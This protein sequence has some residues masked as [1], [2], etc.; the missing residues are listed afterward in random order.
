MATPAERVC[1][2]CSQAFTEASSSNICQQCRSALFSLAGDDEEEDRP[3]EL[4]TNPS[5][6]V[7]NP[8]HRLQGVLS[9]RDFIRKLGAGGMG[10]VSLLRHRRLDRC[11]ALKVLLPALAGS[12]RFVERFLRESKV[13]AQLRHPNIVTVYDCSE[14]DDIL[15]ILM[16][17]VDGGSLREAIADNAFD[18]PKRIDIITQLAEGLA[19]A[20]REGVI[21]RDIKPANILLTQSGEVK[22]ADFGLSKQASTSASE[23]SMTRP[24]EAMGTFGYMAPEQQTGASTGDTRSDVYA[25]G[26]LCYELFTQRLPQGVFPPPSTEAGVSRKIDEVILKALEHDPQARYP[27]AGAFLKAWRSA[28]Q[29]ADSRETSRPRHRTHS[30]VRFFHENKKIGLFAAIAFL[31][32]MLPAFLILRDWLPSSTESDALPNTKQSNEAEVSANLT[33]EFIVP[34]IGIQLKW[35]PPGQTII[36]ALNAD[37][38]DSSPPLS[39]ELSYGFWMGIHEVTQFQFVHVMGSNPSGYGA[40]S[41]SSEA[42]SWRHR[43]VD[44]VSWREAVAFC[45]KLTQ[46]SRASGLIPPNF[47]FR[48][49]TEIEWEYVSRAGNQSISAGSFTPALIKP[50]AWTYQDY[51]EVEETQPV[52][53]K[54][55]NA[56][57]FYDMLGNVS[58]YCLNGWWYYP[59]FENQSIRDFVSE[60]QHEDRIYRGGSFAQGADRAVPYKRSSNALDERDLAQGFRIALSEEFP[61]ISDMLQSA[62][63][64]AINIDALGLSMNWIPA[65]E[66]IMGESTPSGPRGADVYPAT[67]TIISEGFWMGVTEVT[68]FQWDRVSAGDLTWL[69]RQTDT[70]HD[71][72]QDLPANTLSWNEATNFCHKLTIALKEA[73]KLQNDYVIRLPTEAEWE[74]ACRREHATLYTFGDDP[75]DLGIDFGERARFRDNGANTP[76]PVGGKTAGQSGLKGMYGNVREWCQDWKHSYTGQQQT[77]PI[78]KSIPSEVPAKAIRGGDFRSAASLCTGTVRTFAAPTHRS[79]QIGFR[80]VLG[81]PLTPAESPPSPAE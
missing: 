24:Q 14:V 22:I 52:G 28:T 55:P 27:D 58:E 10:S 61:F 30:R 38:T 6:T 73:G 34:D 20:H 74:W 72:A 70:K 25:L 8:W 80:I 29:S 39:V 66:F 44:S 17:Y 62:P 13:L 9:D 50:Y 2:Q 23:L 68:T 60:Y 36:G 42:T 71:S 12:P 32:L 48:L 78:G 64:L 40:D 46:E 35:V 19:Y 77:D 4:T 51:P 65:G 5:A 16:D 3:E 43:P 1:S 18:L 49:P 26:V 31:A 63:P 57:G 7:P 56:W 47:R 75:K 54:M 53:T 59:D 41:P 33:Q 76:G 37:D 45:D 21:H 15:Y 81:R 11:E 69:L 79:E 67:P